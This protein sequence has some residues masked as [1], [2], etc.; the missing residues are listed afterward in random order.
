MQPLTGLH[1]GDPAPSRWAYRLERLMLTPLFRK[2]LRVGLPFCL[3]FIAGTLYFS[4]KD[5]QEAMVQ[6]VADLRA[7]IE[8]RPEFMV[9]LL[10]VDGASTPTETYIRAVFPY[11]FPASSFDLDLA[12]VQALVAD[13]PVVAQAS[14]RIRQG[15]VLAIEVIE[16][17]PVA[18][19]RT[20]NGLGVVDAEGVVIAAV[21]SRSVRPDLPLIAGE[22]A[23]NAVPEALQVLQA[24]APLGAR[25]KGLVRIGARRWDVVLDRDQRILLPEIAP[26]R[27]LERV[28]VLDQVHD[29]LERD[30]AVID[31]RLSERPTLRMTQ[32]A[33]DEWWRVIKLSAGAENQ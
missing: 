20:P 4:D 15:G 21:D 27:A 16:R 33:Q 25:V 17:Q 30:L 12:E 6:A 9:R 28:I 10:A 26:A 18:L 8:T 3:T 23:D 32:S 11:E 7:Q 14:V 19:W 29:M 31:M 13:M 24:A 2:A 5:R 22:G 1:K